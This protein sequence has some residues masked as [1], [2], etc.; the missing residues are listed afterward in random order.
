MPVHHVIERLTTVTY[1]DQMHAHMQYISPVCITSLHYDLQDHLSEVLAVPQSKETCS[2]SL[3]RVA[4]SVLV[5]E[6]QF[7]Q[8]GCIDVLPQFNLLV[9]EL[10][11]LL[12][13]L[14]RYPNRGVRYWYTG[15]NKELTSMQA[16]T[17]DL[18]PSFL[19]GLYFPCSIRAICCMCPQKPMTHYTLCYGPLWLVAVWQCIDSQ[20]GPWRCSWQHSVGLHAS[21]Y[22]SPQCWLS[23]SRGL[24]RCSKYGSNF[25]SD[26]FKFDWPLKLSTPR[27]PVLMMAPLAARY[28]LQETNYC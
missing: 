19:W 21:L 23:P 20:Q 24:Y 11:H 7:V 15:I 16:F 13:F 8:R 28:L 12:R 27:I 17:I 22:I 26:C 5:I 1:P 3:V 25:G 6:L 18:I 9:R 4:H 10:Q 2:Q 14:L